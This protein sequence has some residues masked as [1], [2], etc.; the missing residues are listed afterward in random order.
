M[1][2]SVLILSPEPPYPL[3]GGG[4][5]RIASLVHYFAQ[6]AEVDLVLFSESGQ[7]ALMPPNLLHSQTVI[8]LAHH[9]THAA[10]RYWRNA[11]RAARGVP[12]LVDRLAGHDREL[13]SLLRGK[14]YDLGVVEHFWC[15]PYREQV[16]AVCDRTVLDLHNIESV[17]HERCGKT[18][19]GLVAAGHRRFAK[20]ARALESRLLPVYSL[21]L[22]TS[23]ADAAL[24]RSIA[25]TARVA[26][27][28]NAI[29]DLPVP[30]VAEQNVVVFSG[31]FE[32]HPNID[33]V[34]FLVHSI[35]PEVVKKCPE[36]RLRLVGRGDRFIRHLLPSGM[37]IETTGAI[38]NAMAEIAAARIVVA[39]LRA[40][41][42][43]RIKIV[44]AWAAARPVVATSLAA[45]GLE[46]REGRDLLI[47][48]EGGAIAE[49]IAGLSANPGLRS[50]IAAGGRRL[51]GERYTWQAAWQTLS[52]A[53]PDAP[54]SGVSAPESGMEIAHRYTEDSDE[55]SR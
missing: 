24:A 6:F 41:S 3:Q 46:Y 47:A 39:P 54:A 23:E 29:P 44:E 51:F 13:A 48:N 2:R 7:P 30:A 9:E 4:A 12:P 8:R 15:A 43:T 11:R 16:A 22:T 17:L 42:G 50:E 20:S 25:P 36:L 32:Y 19:T 28:P 34:G 10:A 38:E 33:A 37:K 27:Y 53:F 52:A 1:I 26:V 49:T 45:E 21:L 18:A 35:W 55:N 40:G 14:H 5:Y 31:N